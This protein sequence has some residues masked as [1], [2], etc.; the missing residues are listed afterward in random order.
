MKSNRAV[1]NAF[2]QELCDLLSAHG[3]W[4]KNMKQDS[5]GQPADVIAVRNKVAYLIDCKDC[6]GERFSLRRIE[7]NQETAMTMWE[8]CGNGQGWFAIKFSD[9]IY[10]MNYTKIARLANRCGSLKQDTIACIAITFNEW[11]K[12]CE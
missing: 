8:Q 9:E 7:P 12:K 4:A 1:G 3:F 11:V 5:S 6:S 10:M 2:E